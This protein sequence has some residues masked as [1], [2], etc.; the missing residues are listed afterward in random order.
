MEAT[1]N[2]AFAEYVTCYAETCCGRRR[3]R[4]PKPTNNPAFATLDIKQW[5]GMRGPGCPAVVG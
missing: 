5:H 2:V 3:P 1:S 4:V